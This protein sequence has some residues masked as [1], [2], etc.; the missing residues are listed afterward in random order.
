MWVPEITVPG[1]GCESDN[2]ALDVTTGETSRG[3]L[4]ALG[5]SGGG[6]MDRPAHGSGARFV[7]AGARFV[8]F[9]GLLVDRP[10]WAVIVPPRGCPS[11]RVM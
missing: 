2:V 5:G 8:P 4:D 1:L 10:A 7:P 6:R 3:V 11:G 9:S